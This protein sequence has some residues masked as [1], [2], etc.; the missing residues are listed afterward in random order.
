MTKENNTKD[1]EK[2]EHISLNS[3]RGLLPMN[4]K[5]ALQSSLHLYPDGPWRASRV[6]G[7]TCSNADS[8]SVL[9]GEGCISCRLPGDARATKRP[10]E[11][12]A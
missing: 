12:T 7:D 1:R 10:T 2:N 4:E 8:A 11:L 3:H 6:V 9:Q 5:T